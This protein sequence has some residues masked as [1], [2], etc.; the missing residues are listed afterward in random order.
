MKKIFNWFQSIAK[1]LFYIF[2]VISVVLVLTASYTAYTIFKA[3]LGM[4]TIGRAVTA[5]KPFKVISYQLS[6]SHDEN[7]LIR[8]SA[9]SGSPYFTETIFAAKKNKASGSGDAT[10]F[11]FN[12]G[13][14]VSASV[15]SPDAGR[16][17]TVWIEIQIL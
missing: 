17:V 7:T 1:K 5:T 4:P 13:D 3:D 14:R 15:W 16:T 8:F 11:I 10:D 9:N 6:P 12:K 2:A